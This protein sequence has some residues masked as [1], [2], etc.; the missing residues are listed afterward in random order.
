MP[1]E[2]LSALDASFLAVEGPSAHMHVGWAATFAPPADGPRPDF[3]TLFAH[4]AGRLGRARRFRQRIAPDALGLSAP[5]W[6]D[7]EDFDPADHIH[8]SAAEDLPQLADAVLSE[9]LRRDRPLWEFWIADRLRDGRIGLVGKAHHCMVDGLAAVELGSL[10]LD[11]DPHPGSAEDDSD[12]LPA[13]APHALELLARGA[14]DRTREQLGLLRYPLAVARS[15]MALPALGL[16]TARALAGAVLPVAPSSRLNEPGSPDRHLATARRPFAE[17]LAIRTAHKVTVNDVLLAAVA[18]ALR[19]HAHRAE[20]RPRDL[21]AMVPVNVRADDESVLGNRITF[22]FV[23]LPASVPDPV[24]RLRL[25]GDATRSRKESGVPEDADTALKALAYAPRQVQKAAAHALASP[26]VYNLVVSNIPGPRVP[27]YMAG[28]RLDEAY[29]V[30]PLSARHALSVGM[31]TIGDHACFGLYA[32]PETLPDSDTLARDLDA[33][34]DELR[35]TI[36]E[37]WPT[38][39][40]PRSGSV[41]RFR[42]SPSPTPMA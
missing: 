6:I 29:P 13:P 41:T 9:P 21:K 25:I 27:M 42:R 23:E 1:P 20:E 30:V 33:A 17:L 16:R 11:A 15:P 3:E 26:R 8:R 35:A 28:C 40:R 4:I 37:P 39:S 18:G 19:R 31:T 36:D 38:S 24:V 32:D 2:R 12:W 5:L 34:L 7:A 22:M 10:L 14:W